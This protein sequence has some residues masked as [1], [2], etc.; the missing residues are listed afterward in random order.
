MIDN[1]FES[2]KEKSKIK[3]LI[4]TDFFKAYYPIIENAKLSKEN[5]E[6]F[7]LDLFS[8]PGVYDD[9][10]KSTPLLLLDI[11][12]NFKKDTIR[13]RLR[14]VFNDKNKNYA[15]TL[16]TYV[17][18]HPVYSAMKH[19]PIVTNMQASELNLTKYLCQ[20][21]PIFS[22]VDPWGYVDV[23]AEQVWGLIRNIGSDCILF[24]SSDRIL[25]DLNKSHQNEHFQKMFGNYF[26]EALNIHASKK[27]Q[28]QKCE[29][30]LKLFSQNVKDEMN[31]ESYKQFKLY[32]LPFCVSADDKTKTSH[33]LVFFTKNHKAIKEM[34]NVM[35]KYSNSE[36]LQMGFDSKVNEL[37]MYFIRR[38]DMVEQDIIAIIKQYYIDNG[39]EALTNVNVARIMELLDDDSMQNNHCVLPY[40]YNEIKDA[41]KT[42]DIKGCIDLIIEGSPRSR[43]RI[44]DKQLFNIND[45]ILRE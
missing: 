9:G 30:F 5:D 14:I 23:S 12:N 39:S 1:F 20:N 45:K 16:D 18:N 36:N 33:H 31:K 17:K 7:Y 38:E 42:L 13:E 6:I 35:A 32:I 11:V 41:I 8:G 4:V 44:T 24:F 27:T 29:S 19:S 10:N 28:Q 15:A 26:G 3:S 37:Q 2:Q 34:K 43:K 25:Q 21:S 22:F 40:T